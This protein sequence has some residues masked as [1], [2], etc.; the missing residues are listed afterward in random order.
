MRGGS[1]T[2]EAHPRG[3]Y[4]RLTVTGRYRIAQALSAMLPHL[5]RKKQVVERWL[6]LHKA[7]AEI[8]RLRRRLRLKPGKY[9]RTELRRRLQRI[10]Q[11]VPPPP[12]DTK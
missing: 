10:H 5:V 9:R 2:S 4:Y 3:R 6:L 8:G 1:I 12:G 7:K 11:L